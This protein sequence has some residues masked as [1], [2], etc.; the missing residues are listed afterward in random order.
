MRLRNLF[1]ILLLCMTVGAFGVSCTGD[2]GADGAQGPPGPAGPA[3]DPG[4]DAGSSESNYPFLKTWGDVD[5]RVACDDPLLTE[6]GVFPGPAT[7]KALPTTTESNAV[8]Y[9][10]ADGNTD[11]ANGYVQVDC[12]SA[13]FDENANPDL[14]GDGQDDLAA[15][16]T[17]N[18]GLL[19]VKT[20]RGTEKSSDRTEAT[21]SSPALVTSVTKMFSGGYVFAKM[22]T[23][24]VT[25]EVADRR[26]LYNDCDRGDATA[27]PAIKGHFRA[28]T[29]E[30]KSRNVRLSDTGNT[31]GLE[32]DIPNTMVVKTTKKVCVR[33]DSLP[34]VVKCY[35][36]N[37]VTP[38]T[39]GVGNAEGVEA[40]PGTDTIG[41]YN[42]DGTLTPVM[43]AAQA[44]GA[45]KGQVGPAN[46]IDDEQFIAANRND[47][48][49]QKLCN[50]FDEAAPGF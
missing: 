36:K 46:G 6:K 7:L 11:T 38:D 23:T 2:D 10:A 41:I 34:G 21:S 14:D 26:D 12:D 44:A 48:Q 32:E 18:S 13:V 47:F 33:L 19:F 45:N 22:D 35:V 27:P 3:G 28:V 39:N 43:P 5:G 17:P 4:E 31:R 49:G 24:R 9:A 42:P 25:G 15:G 8:R 50:L 1:M 29:I 40:N 30:D 16:Y 20:E 37:V